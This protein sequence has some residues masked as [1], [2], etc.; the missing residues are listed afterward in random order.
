MLCHRRC[1]AEAATES[2]VEVRGPQTGASRP[3]ADSLGDRVLGREA[4]K[5]EINVIAGTSTARFLSVRCWACTAGLRP[6]SFSDPAGAWGR[7]DPM[8]KIRRLKLSLVWC[9][10]AGHSG[11]PDTVSQDV[12]SS[13]SSCTALQT[14]EDSAS[15]GSLISPGRALGGHACLDRGRSFLLRLLGCVWGSEGHR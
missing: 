5:A 1:S 7:D 12:N 3:S 14:S 10:T 15:G 8:L 13:M 2:Q 11:S 6:R 9:C 4:I